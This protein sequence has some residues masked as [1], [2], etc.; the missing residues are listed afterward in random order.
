MTFGHNSGK[1]RHIF[2]LLLLTN[3]KETVDGSVTSIALL[4]YRVKFENSKLSVNF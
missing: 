1:R 3:S 2:K 4:H